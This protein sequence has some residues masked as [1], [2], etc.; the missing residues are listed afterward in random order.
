[1]RQQ[2]TAIRI[3]FFLFVC[4]KNS[5]LGKNFSQI[6]SQMNYLILKDFVPAFVMRLKN[7][8]R[9]PQKISLFIT[10]SGT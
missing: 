5:C 2:R 4:E 8:S 3:P 10:T 6:S 7:F 1:M 9:E